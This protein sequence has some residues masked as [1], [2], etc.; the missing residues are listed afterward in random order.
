MSQNL[1]VGVARLEL[2]I[3]EA[4]SLKDR[5]RALRP[6]IERL[7]NRHRVLVIETGHTDLHQRAALAICG[8]S[9]TA[10][11]L[12]QRF[13]RVHRTVDEIWAGVILSWDVELVQV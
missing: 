1:F 7:R 9:T 12:E 3:P 11:D 6:L 8:V 2:H 4:R 5:R 13:D 10:A